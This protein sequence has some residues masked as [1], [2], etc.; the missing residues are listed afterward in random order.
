M[1]E[2]KIAH[3]AGETAAPGGAQ[4][5]R[6]FDRARSGRDALAILIVLAA[7]TLC[8]LPRLRGPIDLR[9]DGSVYYVLGT[10]LAQGKGYRLLNEPGEVQAI[11][12]PPLLPSIVA[13]HQ[14]LSGSSDFLVVGP[15]LRVFYLVLSASLTVAAYLLARRYLPLRFALPATFVLLLSFW[16]HYL[17]DV[18]YAEIPYTLATVVFFLVNRPGRYPARSLL[19]GALAAAA[20]LL[21]TAGI[22]LLVAWVAESLVRRRY[23][24]ALLRTAM[25]LVPIVLWQAHIVGVLRS[26]EYRQPPYAYQRADYQNSNVTYVENSALID[27]FRPE[28]GRAGTIG[29]LRRLGWNLTVMPLALGEAVSAPAAFWERTHLATVLSQIGSRAVVPSWSVAIPIALAGCA[30][31]AG[32]VRLW[33]AQERL[34]PLYLAAYIAVTSITPWPEQFPRYMMPLTPF[35]ALALFNTVA[36][37]MAWHRRQAHGWKRRASLVLT[38]SLLGVLFLVGALTMTHAYV[39]GRVLVTYYD[40][41]GHETR[42]P[43]FYDDPASESLNA[44]LEW[45]RRHGRRGEIVAATAP[46][47]A[48]LRSG[49]KA[50][51]PPMVI[52][53]ERAQRLLD[54]AR[55]KYVLLDTLGWPGISERYAAPTIERNPTRWR[56]VY[57]APGGAARVYERVE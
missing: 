11:Q 18:L 13:A 4:P 40:S 17:A 25:A 33:R 50:I 36:A 44:A 47:F 32:V 37:G 3:S 34:I 19:M 8:W 38:V 48:Y 27:P 28:L 14:W 16:F 24:Q 31:I 10:A 5:T 46:H 51:L 21:R 54:S 20:Y 15:R 12:Y 42:Y 23:R 56:L 35:L 41:T 7:V 30:I 2:A 49:L 39:R 57:V 9:W 43:L 53:P 1:P 6:G 22:A 26:D 52:D 45:L 55:V 29:L